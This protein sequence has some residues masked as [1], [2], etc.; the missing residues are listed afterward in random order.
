MQDIQKLLEEIIRYVGGIQ[1]IVNATHCLTRLRLVLRD[2]SL[3]EKEKLEDVKGVVMV[4]HAGS[5]VQIVITQQVG[6]VYDEL[7]KIVGRG[8]VRTN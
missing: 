8:S 2:E 5:Q 3:E 1:N 4:V 7:C 6:K